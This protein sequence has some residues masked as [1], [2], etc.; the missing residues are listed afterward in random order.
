M[1]SLLS[2][3]TLGLGQ[4]I[5]FSPPTRFVFVFCMIQYL[6]SSYNATLG[7]VTA[8]VYTVTTRLSY[9]VFTAA[10]EV[11]ETSKNNSLLDLLT[12]IILPVVLLFL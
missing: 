12:V 5:L 9:R 1:V 4:S 6:H 2:G 7:N 11:L 3:R 10:G 8:Q